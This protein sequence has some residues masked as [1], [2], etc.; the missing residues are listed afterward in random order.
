[1][2]EGLKSIKSA[3][4]NLGLKAAFK[5]KTKANKPQAMHTYIYIY[6]YL[7]LKEN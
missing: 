4:T 6:I 3:T 2:A 1:V 5:H 7:R